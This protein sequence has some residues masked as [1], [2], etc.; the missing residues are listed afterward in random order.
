MEHSRDLCVGKVTGTQG[1]QKTGWGGRRQGC[2]V[3]EEQSVLEVFHHGGGGSAVR[4]AEAAGVREQNRVH[5]AVSKPGAVGCF[6]LGF[7][8]P[9]QWSGHRVR[10]FY[11]PTEQG[12]FGSM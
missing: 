10:A 6:S 8:I 11:P 9:L 12:A 3:G 1:L 4:S 7:N 2:P 5:N